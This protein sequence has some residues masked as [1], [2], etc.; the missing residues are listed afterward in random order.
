MAFE[1]FSWREAGL[2]LGVLSPVVVASVLFG[3]LSADLKNH[4]ERY[5]EHVSTVTAELKVITEREERRTRDCRAE[6]SIAIDAIRAEVHDDIN[7][8]RDL[9]RAEVGRWTP[10]IEANR[11]K[12]DIGDRFTRRDG[13]KLAADLAGV[14]TEQDQVQTRLGVIDQRLNYLERANHVHNHQRQG[15]INPQLG[16]DFQ[17]GPI[18][19]E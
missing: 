10:I 5:N 9:L 18:G 7:D 12:L 6:R 1:A 3:V 13:D 4:R 8:T 2:I 19:G 17:F 11:Q 16:D 15:L 14:A